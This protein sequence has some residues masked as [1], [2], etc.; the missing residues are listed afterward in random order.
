[1]K[2][3]SIQYHKVF[4]LG[5]FQ[6]EKIGVEVEVQPDE[7]PTKALNEAKKFVELSSTSYKKKVERAQ[8]IVNN[9]HH[10]QYGAVEEA[11]SFLSKIE[12]LPNQLLNERSEEE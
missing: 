2:I 6:N 9:P 11:K 8:E 4:N 7:D 10:Y 1:M 5:D 12:H 3:T